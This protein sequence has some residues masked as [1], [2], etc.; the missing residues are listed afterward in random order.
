MIVPAQGKS[1]P[2]QD[3]DIQEI[4][5]GNHAV[6]LKT[7]GN[8]IFQFDSPLYCQPAALTIAPYYKC[9]TAPWQL[10]TPFDA[11]LLYSFPKQDATPLT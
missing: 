3:S 11:K 7:K 4:V 9:L 10:S 6:A 5:Y 1:F 2:L 8:F